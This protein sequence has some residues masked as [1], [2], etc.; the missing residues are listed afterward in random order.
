MW[1]IIAGD[2]WVI[3]IAMIMSM[4]INCEEEKAI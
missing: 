4:K 1:A 3:G 2:S